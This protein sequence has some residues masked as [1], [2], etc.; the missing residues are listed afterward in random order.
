MPLAEGDER[1]EFIIGATVSSFGT[2]RAK[3]TKAFLTEDNLARVEAFFE[4]ESKMCIVLPPS[5]KVEEGFPSKLSNKG[6][7][8]IFLKQKAA[9]VSAKFPVAQQLLT[10][11]VSGS[12][13]FEHLE[14]VASEVFL[15][16][17]SNPGNQLKWGEVA[18]REILDR[19][20]AFLSSTTILCGHVKGET[21]LP[22]PPDEQ[23]D[24]NVKNRIS[25]LEGAVITWTKQIKS[26]LKQD[27]ES[28]LKLG[29]DPTPDV[30]IEF[31]KSKA[32]NLNSIFDQLQSQ[33]I[34]RVLRALD[35]AKST[36][37]TTFARL[38]KEVYT[39]RLESNDN[40]KYLRTLEYWFGR[41][42]AEDDFPG[43]QELFKPMLH[44]ILLIWKNSK[45]YN[46]PARLVV[47]MREICNSLINQ[48]CKYVSGEQIF[49]LIEADEA[50]VAVEQ[51]KTTL[52]VCGAFKSTY[53]EYRKTADAECPGNQWRIQNNA[54][55]MRL[56][57]FLERCH[58]ILDL[59]QTIVQFSKLAKIEVGG[60]KGKT[61]TASVQQIHF[62][63]MSAVELFK[64][65]PYDIMDVG[66]KQFD[67]DFY[68]FRCAIKEL[69]RRLGAVVSLAFDDSNTVYGRFK[70]FDSFDGLLERPII[71]D[72][73]E[74]KY[75]SL[76]Q[77]YGCDLKRVQELFLY[78]RDAPPIASNLPPV[79]GAL[80]WCRGLLDRIRIAMEKLVALDASILEREESREVL[81]VYSTMKSSLEEYENQKIEEWGRDVEASSS[82]KLRLP[83]LLRQADCSL[84]VNFDAALVRLLREVKYFLLMGLSV[85]DSALAIYEQV[86]TFRAW[87]GQLDLIVHKYNVDLMRLLP[88]EKPLLQ[89]YLDRFD[90]AVEA[91]LS[92]LNWET[93]GSE[94]EIEKRR[95]FIA[96]ATEAVHVVDDIT[97]TMKTNLEKVNCIM[98]SWTEKPL[99]E[100]K[101][102]PQELDYFERLFK[103]GRAARYAEIKEGGKEIERM[104]KETNKILRVSNAS[105]NW[106]A[107][108]DFI[109]NIVVD[110]L[111]SVITCSLEYFLM[112]IDPVVIAQSHGNQLPMLE[113]K[114]D[115]IDK[116]PTFDPV[117]GSH[118]G[119]GMRDVSAAW[120]GSFFHVATLFKRLDTDGTYV[121]EMHTDAD[122][123][124]LMAEIEETQSGNELMLGD[125][126]EQFNELSFLWKRDREA[127]FLQ[128]TQEAVLKTGEGSY[129]DLNKY[130]AAISKYLDVADRIKKTKSLCDVGWLRVNTAPIKSSLLELAEMWRDLHAEHLRNH[131][132]QTLDRFDAFLEQVKVG[133]ALAVDD[134]DEGQKNLRN[135][136]SDIL[137]V[138]RAE[139][140]TK[141]MFQ[142]LRELC[143]LLKHHQVDIT[144]EVVPSA[145]EARRRKQD[146][147]LP[148]VKTVLDY[149]E[150][151]PVN[152]AAVVKVK[153]AKKDEIALY[154]QK[155][156]FSLKAELD[157]FY[158]EMRD[159][160][161]DFRAKAPFT[162]QGLSE[163]AY[164]L[165]DKYAAELE[166]FER[167]AAEMNRQ[168]ELFEL[169]VSK[170]P[171]LPQTLSELRLL[172]N[173][174]DF[175]AM[176]QYSYS[177]WKKS[178]WSAVD[179]DKL[180]VENKALLKA[181]RA[182]GA[183][184]PVVKGWVV[185][186]DIEAAIRNM[187]IVLPLIADLHSDALAPRHWSQLARVCKASVVDPTQPEFLLQD[188]MKFNLHE[189]VEEVQEVVET[190]QKEKK[191]EKKLEDIS[192]SWGGFMLEYVKHKDTEMSLIRL[193]EEIIESLDAHMLELQT[194]LGMGKFVEFFRPKVEKWQATLSD[195]QEVI[196]LWE[197]VSRSWASLESIFL[198]SA[199]IRSQLADVTKVF[200]SIDGEF[201]EMMREAVNEPNVVQACT[202]DGRELNLTRWKAG[203]DQCQKSL[204]EYLDRKKEMFPRFYFVSAVALLDMLANGTNP[205]KIM[206]YLGDC[207]DALA[208]LSFVKDNE[209]NESN[210]TADV[211]IAKDREQI[212]MHSPFTMEG[213][214]EVYLNKLTAAMMHT[215]RHQLLRGIEDGVNWDVDPNLPRH[216]WLFKYPAQVVLTGSLIYWTEETE[217]SLEELEGGKEDAVKLVSANVK[218]RLTKLILLV[219]GKLTHD[220]RTKT[221]TLI[222]MD[223]HGRDVLGTLIDTKTEG[224]SAFIWQQQLRFYWEQDALDVNIKICDFRTKYF[225]E[226]TGN[227]GRLVITALT[228][229]C[230]ITLTMGLR[231]F[232]GGAPAGPAGTGKTETTKDLARALALPCY[233]FNCSDQM[234]YQSMADIFRGL[235]QTGAWGCFD[236]F[237]RISIEVLSVVATQVKTV[238]DA[239]VKFAV[240]SRRS[241]E[242]QHLPAG[243]PPCKVGKFDFFGGLID[244][245][246]TVGFY[247]TMNPGYAG[248]TELPENLKALFR[249]CAMIRPDLKPI[250]ENM[251]MSEGFQTAQALAIKFVTLYELSDSLL[252]KQAHYD[253]GLRAVKSVLRVA[254]MLKRGEPHLDEA[255][256]LM[257]ALRDFNIAKIVQVDEVVFFGLLNDLFPGLDPPRQIDASLETSVDAAIAASGQFGDDVMRLKCVQ[258]DELLAIR[259]CVFVMGP[260][261]AF[262]TTCWKLL[263][264]AKAIKDPSLSVK[265]VDINPKTMP[266]Q[267]LYGYINM[268]TRDWKDGL[269][270]T[271]MRDLG[272][273]PDEKP[274]W[275]LLDGDLDANWIESMNSVMDD[276]RML[277]LASNER[278]P[279]KPHMRMIFE[280]RD[281]KHA[282]P[283]T[284]SRAG[285]LYISTD[286]GTQWKSLIASYISKRSESDQVKVWLAE[287]CE[288]YVGES[289]FWMKINVKTVLPL[290]DMNLVQ[291]LL[292][293]LTATLDKRNCESKDDLEI[294]FNFCAVWALGSSLGTS[295]DGVAYRLLLSDFWRANFKAVKFPSRGASTSVFDYW[296][297]PETNVYESWSKS[298][299]MEDVAFDSRRD[300]MSQITVPTGETCSV[301]FWMKKMVDARNPIMLAGPAGTGKTQQVMGMLGKENAAETCSTTIN[302]NF[303]TTSA[304]LQTTMAL[305]LEKKTGTNFGP[306]G[307]SWL[308]Y[309]VD[310][311]NLP[312]LDAYNT[313]SAIALLRQQMEYGHVYDMTKLAQNPLKNIS[314]TQVVA[315][316]NPTAGSFEINPRLQRWFVT[317]AIG[318]PSRTSLHHIYETFLNG[319]LESGGFNEEVC[320]LESNIIKAALNL[321]K[322]VME[323]FRKTATNFHYE[324]NIRHLANVFQGLL[325]A[326]A[327]QIQTGEKFVH[328]WLHES[329]RVYGDRLVSAEHLLQ[330]NGLAQT[331][332]KKLFSQYAVDKFYAKENSEPLIFC[333]FCD[334]IEERVYDQVP[335]IEQ[336]AR[337]LEGALELYNET[338]AVM[339]LVLFEDAMKHL[340]RIARIILNEGGHALLVG[341]GGSGKQS[342]SR[343]AA[344]ICQYTVTQIVISSTYSINDLKDDLKGMYNKAG[345]KEEGVM[346]LLTDSQITNERFL[347]YI[348]DLLASGNIPDLF[349]QDDVDNIVN[350]V[351]NKVKASGKEPDKANCWDYFIRQIR[352]N[353]HVV[354]AFS[355]VGD[356]FRNRSRKFPAL[357][358]STVI[359]WFQPWPEEALLSVGQRFL[360]AVEM[361]ADPKVR[362]AIEKFMPFSFIE[363]NKLAKEFKDVERR[364][365]YTTPKSFLELLKL[366]AGLLEQKRSE[367]DRS[368]TRLRTGLKKMQETSDA[369]GEIE[370]SLRITLE[371]AEVKKTRAEGIAEIVSKEK[372]I[373]ETETAKAEV[374]A[375]EVS[376]V[377]TEVSEKQRS[378][379]EDLAKAEPAVKA[380]M[381]ALESLDAKSLA[382]CKTMVKPPYG[383]EDVFVASMCLLAGISPSVTHKNLKIKERTWDAAKKQCLGNIKEYIEY[384]KMI[385]VKVDESGDLTVQMK[386][387][388]PY[389]E[390]EHF[391]PEI[392][393]GKNSAAAGVTSF[394][395]NIVMYYDIVVT[396]EPKRI[397]LGLA[398]K[399]LEDANARLKVVN[400]LVADLQSKLAKLTDELEKAEAEKA[401]AMDLVERGQR[402]LDLAQRL[403]SALASENE[404]WK[405]SVEI[406][407]AS[408]NLLTG[409]VLL[410]SAFISYAGPF[411]KH[412]R[413]KLMGQKFFTYLKTAFGGDA[414]P[415]EGEADHGMPMSPDLNVLGILT[416]DADIAVWNQDSLPAD[417]V[418]TENG[419][420]VSNTARW[421]LIIDPQLQGIVWL[422]N[423][424]SAAARNLQVVRL[425]QKDMMRKLERALENGHTILIENLPETL[426][427]VLNPVIQRATIKRGRTLYVKLGDTEVE[428]HPN[429]KL[430]LH[431][432]LS[433]PHYPPEVQA[434]CTLINFT[435][436][437][438][439][440]SD[441]LLSLVV[442]KERE[443]LAELAESL[444][445]QQNGFKIKM[446]ELE[447]S[448][449][450][451]LANAE[452]DITEDVALIEGL[453]ETKKIS[454]DIFKKSAAAKETQANIM[455]TSLKYKPVADRS[456]AL[457]FLMNDLSKV[458]SYY[459]Y[460]LAAFTKVFYRGI[461]AVTRGTGAK[462]VGDDGEEEEEEEEV[463]AS[464]LTDAEL[465]VRCEVLK[466]SITLTSFNYIR[467][468]L[469]ERHKLTVSTM[470]TLRIAVT[471]ELLSMDDV[472]YLYVGKI[473]TDPGN[474]GP[475]H[476]WM[477]EAIWP[478]VKALEGLKRF[479]GIGDAMHSD[480]DEWL[481]WFDNAAPEVARLPGDYQKTL[482]AFDRLILIRA[483]RP[484]R[485]STLMQSY[486]SSTMG[487]DYVF[488][489]PFDMPATYEETTNQ[490][491]VFFVLFP[492]VDPTPWVE[493]LGRDKGISTEAGTFCNISMGQGQEKP[494]EAV[495]ERFAKTGGW[496]MLQ[497]CHLMTSWVPNLERLLEVVQENAHPDFRCFLSAEPPPALP[498]A[499]NMPESLM[500]AS[501][502]VA[503]EAP[504][505]IKSNL[506]RAWANFSQDRI[507]ACTKPDDFKACLFSLCWFHSIVLG[508]RRFGAQG[509]SRAYSFNTGDLT[510]CSNVLT[511]YLDNNP[512]VPWDDIRYLFGE[513]MY[514]GHITDPWDRRTNNT[515]LLVL[516]HEDLRSGLELGPGF[517]SPD[518]TTVDYQGYLS[519]V[520]EN[521]PGETPPQFGLH[522]NAEIG[523][524]TTTTAD[525]F[526]TIL[527][528]GGGSGPAAGGGDV[529]KQ[530]M[531]DLK[532]RCPEKLEMVSITRMAEPLLQVPEQGPYVVCAL[533]ECRR[534]NV[535]LDEI[536][537][538]LTELEKGLGGQLNMTQA[539]E[540]MCTAFTI[541]QWPGRNP[542]DGCTW[543]K[544]AWPSKKGLLPQFFD[545]LKRHAQLVSWTET[546]TTPLSVWLSGLFNPMAYLTG[547]TQITARATGAPLDKMTQ[548]TFV[549]TYLNP[550][551]IPNTEF[552]DAGAYVHGLFIEGA[553]WPV[554]DEVDEV[555]ELG[556]ASVG[557]VLME[558]RLKELMPPMPV[559]YI[560]AV[561]V[562]DSWEASAVGYL[563]HVPDVYESPVFITTMRGPTYLFLATLKTSEA[564]SK[565]TLTGTA[566]ML[567]QDD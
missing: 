350:T 406:M 477:P 411:T 457:F 107:Y 505:D 277:T 225:Y 319:H 174:W 375:R 332:A 274:K 553:R 489:Q 415:A 79:S 521:L 234:N 476:E 112:Q 441:Q 546:L 215:L 176:V 28:Q 132:I 299:F 211:M 187:S 365:V 325:V 328:L 403:T 44:I 385:K 359:D 460:S 517:K 431:T 507:D 520:E 149:L 295:D 154:K 316:M 210:K 179:T 110:G 142:P 483:M 208:N 52:Q 63:F 292:H 499:K 118:H 71:Q 317:F 327:D 538:T 194:M 554:G 374:E 451:K 312:E 153:Y 269:L 401:E 302:F 207:Y 206:P 9:P 356:D 14:L 72:E 548:E 30:E 204:N 217:Q 368:I 372:Q 109:N 479:A 363:V 168:E 285:I 437:Q 452:G 119:K 43:L 69:E 89:P 10:M 278:I 191:I 307:Q 160:R 78:Y 221:I 164:A 500:Q 262:K 20:V 326:N 260:P 73:L 121:R 219:L 534:M 435:V 167:R 511:S 309:F 491:P 94:S 522:P 90:K 550:D 335:A 293:F 310:D 423:K 472:M 425:G 245:I 336:L 131:L 442:R 36:Y 344:F 373:V 12:S 242:Y 291:S 270:S 105:L 549:T 169:S 275:I 261:G 394:V 223:V 296:L 544:F 339:D 97:C 539:M 398:N 543:E 558:S 55:F 413:D 26:V 256:I 213:E 391:Q 2:D 468:G 440:L 502:K 289:L 186:R 116:E 448:I 541:N 392:I 330:Y 229:R 51:L 486:I 341:V 271:I 494:A 276:N 157:F 7:S 473:A 506:V 18:A 419:T 354:L 104:L 515:Y 294:V 454:I 158:S 416:T 255:Q 475:L 117:I 353:L 197:S 386:E 280:I 306:P 492:G 314:K 493:G 39:A 343:L 58:D 147:L 41:L 399:Q 205:K 166:A 126:K 106:R 519:Y 324:F 524:L 371:D 60:T 288:A 13:P 75:V 251:L 264:Q 21:R 156:E 178:K 92:L 192:A 381:A 364:H 501:V 183:A 209:G 470:V 184:D 22:M 388:R 227:V 244:L 430:Y 535:L 349:A 66:A 297:N 531:H 57:S 315:C 518:P 367:S 248:R 214:V 560:K 143:A 134:G 4:E 384:L 409:D 27:P 272:Q 220:E 445:K 462:V 199:D 369:V 433:N 390:L 443:D 86:E 77:S 449:L 267:D 193:N 407:K 165:I 405:E 346:F 68:G 93:G 348:N 16:V 84:T 138:G 108:M 237:N 141:E 238:Q 257:R 563:R 566:L 446:K 287:L 152:W 258:L 334:D 247:I 80:K 487:P 567:Q 459:V 488:Q 439:G 19:F 529:V 542:F 254:G 230:Y 74:K 480:S 304:V 235:A 418:S 284:V 382:E 195:V 246:P 485:V 422:R 338:N 196:K 383:V 216:K 139:N 140:V 114:L 545:L 481:S 226:W 24:A 331:Q 432:K 103:V 456:S 380:A 273:I 547:V 404:R 490:T 453:E 323:K 232:L 528:L 189:Y 434:E 263:A 32:N 122:V 62:D 59:T 241:A 345:L 321:H 340:A 100:R 397:A 15:P 414:V 231:L 376:K 163:E 6:K 56:D 463:D 329:E 426:D 516:M 378:T 91:G 85:P 87:T 551:A 337:I 35:L 38:C 31:W 303:Y 458:H 512:V 88:V 497:N 523:Y 201:K 362:D 1:L 429:F 525:L 527:S 552:P 133:L 127:S 45:H 466:K 526:Q 128:F 530:T 125:L 421:P 305:P 342:L 17:L 95:D 8:V 396:V 508:R 357:I 286:A 99:M 387:V 514:G 420:I 408:R 181:L 120:V 200:E 190:A 252:S 565:W 279:L 233:V 249:S 510:I 496:V 3:F 25:L 96:E 504:A 474:M 532:A 11:E 555:E 148:S 155:A 393:M 536:L 29:R 561:A 259:H 498:G 76:V 34:R 298:P 484:D 509:W 171:E 282:T 240:A 311:L 123:C 135:V 444:V 33:R 188:M 379:S 185:F 61:L 352:K 23:A 150:E 564:K 377:Q 70:L 410:A 50:N 290:E 402:K 180:E 318:M 465:E 130:D 212:R 40:M 42:N 243:T 400:E 540:D 533:Q 111:A 478:R 253:W 358:N 175:K 145:T 461:D 300:V 395:I 224:P 265:V 47:L 447:D 236:E 361:G 559:L 222:T 146:P 557:G 308:V 467:R 144:A 464:E 67:D 83:L 283:A 136:M 366:Y 495:L 333:H 301:N 173:L 438:G 48:A 202:V 313:Q 428:F 239:I 450:E 137:E 455:V 113:I 424:E 65:V 228:D 513:I 182:S 562:E 115:L 266:T 124:L 101:P 151:A 5:C 203:L 427:A 129:L 389:L 198:T 351:A 417:P 268:V 54:V 469:F 98:D 503:N 482:T 172:R 218:D 556:G 360:S 471:D 322:E 537:K 250:C 46:T 49:A 320:A 436:T 170:Y 53:K 81:K 177:G 159:F 64:A 355:P 412:F 370:A 37:C 162:H 347:I 281:L 102:K 161:G 82:S